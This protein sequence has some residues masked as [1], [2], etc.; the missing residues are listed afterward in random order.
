MASAP[1]HKLRVRNARQVVTVTNAGQPFLRGADMNNI[2]ILEAGA[3]NVGI[4][5]V[6]ALDGRIEAIAPESEL[7]TRY[8]E[9]SFASEIDAT[10]KSIVPGFV[11]GHTHPVWSG[12]RVHEFA[13][14]LA[15][16]TYMDIHKRGGGIGFTVRHTRD[17]SEEELLELLLPRLARMSRFGTTLVEAKSGTPVSRKRA[18]TADTLTHAC[19]HMLFEQVM[20]WSATPR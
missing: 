18:F 3:D 4:G 13:L 14:K 20:D 16:A 7:A 9:A 5:I 1:T 11:D 17:S 10:G 8:P 19:S 15:G 2:H 12:D 6:V